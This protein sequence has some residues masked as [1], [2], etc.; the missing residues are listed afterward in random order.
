M[1]STTVMCSSPGHLHRPSARS[2]LTPSAI[3]SPGS[4]Q[5]QGGSTVRIHSAPGRV[6]C[7]YSLST[8]ARPH[9]GQGSAEKK[10]FPHLRHHTL[11]A[12]TKKESERVEDKAVSRR[13]ILHTFTRPHSQ[14]LALRCILLTHLSGVGHSTA[15]R[16]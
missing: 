1:S 9:G 3:S 13:S 6:H 12:Q 11:Y 16:S 10:C 7:T 8:R 5:H 4:L 15:C 14:S 2:G